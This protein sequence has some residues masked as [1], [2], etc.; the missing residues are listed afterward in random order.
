MMRKLTCIGC[1][2]G[3]ELS[4]DVEDGV[5]RSVTG[6]GCN[7]GKRYAETEVTAPT[8]MVT[9]TAPSASG[10]PVP[11]KTQTAVPKDKIFEVVDAIKH[12]AVKL[13]AKIGDVVVVNAA[14]TGVNVIV[15][16]STET[17]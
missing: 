15:T 14:G 2:M 4:V 11:V 13:P 3:C 12:S 10:R 9:S 8:R 17:E 5:V 16:K 1:P 6:N 7:I